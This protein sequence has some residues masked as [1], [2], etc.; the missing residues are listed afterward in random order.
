MR[1]RWNN[2]GIALAIV[3]GLTALGFGIWPIQPPQ[4]R[5]EIG[6]AWGIGVYVVG[7][8]FIVSAFVAHARP[9]LARAILLVGA[10]ALLGSGL[11][12]GRTWSVIQLGALA[13]LFDVLP[14]ILALAAAALIGPIEQSEAE[15]R[16]QERGAM[17]D[18]PLSVEE[19][20]R[21]ERE[22]AA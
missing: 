2:I 6:V 16:A 5:G 9:W 17:P 1:I 7:T 14:A 3:A 19:Q 18:L 22:R 11:T 12:F 8:A 15:R 20:A 13:A 4:G 10:V 21:Q